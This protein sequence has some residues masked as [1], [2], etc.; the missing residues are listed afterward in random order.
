MA[1]LAASASA[2]TIP[3][4]YIVVLKGSV[5][6]PAAVAA[7]H[8]RKHG[9]QKSHVYRKALKG[10]AAAISE[11]QLRALRAD[12]RVA[13][14]AP[15]QEGFIAAQLLPRGIDRID[16]EASSTVA[17]NGSGTVN[18]N[19]AVLDTGTD[20]SHPDLNVVGGTNCVPDG[21]P[22][23]TDPNGHGTHVGGTIGALD[24]G[25]GVVGVAPGTRLFSLKVGDRKGALQLS[26]VI[27]GIDWVTATRTD[28][29]PANDI[30]V[31]NMS[32]VAAG[33][34]S[35]NCGPSSQD[36]MHIAICASTA[37]GV[38][39]VA[40]AG[41]GSVDFH[42]WHPATYDEVLAVTAL[43]DFDGR[44]GA[45]ATT[46]ECKYKAVKKGVEAV[47]DTAASFSNFATLASDAAHAVAAPGVCILSTFPVE[48]ARGKP[49]QIT[50]AGYAL[51]EGTSMASPHVAGTVALCIS[52][53][54]C[55]G[56]TPAQI[57]DK[58]VAGAA[59]YNTANPGYGFQ[60]DPLRPIT[61]KYYGYLIRA[62]LY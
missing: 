20:A 26:W 41:N 7:D 18:L 8:A 6:D 14:V 54:E 56:L 22:S 33:S 9:V 46:S 5:G 42:D 3:G 32:L 28:S 16:G 23:L 47:D 55:A 50:S 27:C 39:Y 35:G 37:A 12:T 34:D 4:R 60:G 38:T 13:F 30:S 24:N 44:P 19:V 1:S 2:A 43:A 51:W 61:G 21:Y 31:A 25:V 49:T 15:D 29:D 57:I 11:G 36:A 52:T 45:A 58:T 62:G 10:Y 48:G 17:G 53:G 40:S 59:A